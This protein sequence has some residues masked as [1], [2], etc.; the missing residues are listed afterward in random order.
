M[1]FDLLVQMFSFPDLV[2]NTW[3]IAVPFW[4]LPLVMQVPRINIIII[5]INNNDNNNDNANANAIANDNNI[6]KDT[7]PPTRFSAPDIQH[8]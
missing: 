5:I 7:K 6:Q 4:K 8:L 1:G 3:Y 2:Q